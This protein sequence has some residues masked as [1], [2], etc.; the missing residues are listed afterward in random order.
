MGNKRMKI[1]YIIA[2]YRTDTIYE[3]LKNIRKAEKVAVEYWKKGY[4]VICPHKNSALLNGATDEK[5]FLD[6]YIEILTRCDL[7]VVLKGYDKSSGSKKE[8][9]IAKEYKIDIIYL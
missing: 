2:P 3:T 8:I 1:A 4:A 6:G 5:V 7:C 9:E